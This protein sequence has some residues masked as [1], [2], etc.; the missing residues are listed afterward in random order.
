MSRLTLR[1]T[2]TGWRP[3]FAAQRPAVALSCAAAA[4]AIPTASLLRASGFGPL[5]VLIGTGGIGTSA[6]LAAAL[7][8]PDTWLSPSVRESIRNARTR[9]MD[10]MGR[11]GGRGGGR[12]RMIGMGGKGRIGGRGRKGVV[13]RAEMDGAV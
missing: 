4:T 13:A 12:G 6:A 3:F 7:S 1:L 8:V 10:G 2:Q 11:I 9:L 5:I